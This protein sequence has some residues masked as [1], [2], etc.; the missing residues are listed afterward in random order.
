M[1]VLQ[2]EQLL[3]FLFTKAG[4]NTVFFYWFIDIHT[5]LITTKYNGEIK[6]IFYKNSIVNCTNVF[7]GIFAITYKI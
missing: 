2:S 7:V 6:A 3:Y 1:T 4:L 5:E